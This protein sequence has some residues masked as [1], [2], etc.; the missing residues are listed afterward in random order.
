MFSSGGNLDSP[1]IGYW[2][3]NLCDF[4]YYTGRYRIVG[5]G[6]MFDEKN[7]VLKSRETLP[8]RAKQRRIYL[9]IKELER[10]PKIV[11]PIGLMRRI[12]RSEARVISLPYI[13]PFLLSSNCGTL[14]YIRRKYIVL[15]HLFLYHLGAWTLERLTSYLTTGKYLKEFIL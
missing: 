5:Y 13:T 3:Q 14:H 15:G 12:P 2:K 1:N 7:W 8:L 10:E 11:L 9:S 4:K 6:E